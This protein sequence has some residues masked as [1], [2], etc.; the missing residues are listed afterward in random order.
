VTV[1]SATRNGGARNY[2]CS[3]VAHATSW[4]QQR[5]TCRR[6]VEREPHQS[7][8]PGAGFGWQRYLADDLDLGADLR[9]QPSPLASGALLRV[10]IASAQRRRL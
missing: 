4:H 1:G 6:L 9:L 8:V 7:L 3:A 2:T 10:R 5:A